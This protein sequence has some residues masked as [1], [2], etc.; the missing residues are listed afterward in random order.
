MVP[1]PINSLRPFN[2]S[3]LRLA[4]KTW[5]HQRIASSAIGGTG[6]IAMVSA[7]EG[8]ANGRV[9]SMWCRRM[10]GLGVANALPRLRLAPCLHAHVRWVRPFKWNL[11][12]DWGS[13]DLRG[14]QRKR[15][16]DFERM[17]R[18]GG[19]PWDRQGF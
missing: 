13:C 17:P 5:N 11:W 12:S 15:F 8:G 4:A 3:E 9:W 18:D 14:G 2:I 1:R 6:V 7:A 16:R 10:E 19:T